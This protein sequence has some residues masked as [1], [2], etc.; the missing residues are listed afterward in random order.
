M[1]PQVPGLAE[2]TYDA[3]PSPWPQALQVL[4]GF[5]F[6]TDGDGGRAAGSLGAFPERPWLRTPREGTEVL[7][8]I[9]ALRRAPG[10]RRTPREPQTWFM[11][12]RGLGVLLARG[13]G[14]Q[15]PLPGAAARW[16]QAAGV[17]A[18][19]AL[20]WLFHLGWGWGWWGTA[21]GWGV[22]GWEGGGQGRGHALYG[23]HVSDA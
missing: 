21:S 7:G 5:G 16:E 10:G 3:R 20:I 8:E 18:G 12:G 19:P 2:H 22:R 11:R 13:V 14:R 15:T 9:C 6:P 17:A 1:Q 23:E 4:G